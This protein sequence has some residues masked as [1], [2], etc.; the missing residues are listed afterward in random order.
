MLLDVAAAAVFLTLGNVVFRRFDP[1]MPLSRRL[2]KTLLLLAITAFISWYFG[3]R[4]V[5]IAFGL[6]MLPVL[7]IH[8][9]WLPRHGVNGWTAEP[10]EKYHAL[11]GWPPP[12]AA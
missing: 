6:A 9:I 1:H 4:G 10:R 3:R 2:L 7:Y 5:L 11:R 12:P 8:G